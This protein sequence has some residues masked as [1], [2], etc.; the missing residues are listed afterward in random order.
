[1]TTHNRTLSILLIGL[2]I[3]Q[4]IGCTRSSPTN[5]V[6]IAELVG[7]WQGAYDATSSLLTT[8]DRPVLVLSSQH[9]FELD[10]IPFDWETDVFLFG[11]S[12]TW[13]LVRDASSIYLQLK[14]DLTVPH[15]SNKVPLP[16]GLNGIT[17]GIERHRTSI[18]LR[19]QWQDPD[20][21]YDIIFAMTRKETTSQ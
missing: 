14:F 21:H 2:V 9:R 20:L 10:L 1:M 13:E 19:Y 8:I 3:A 5:D 18:R 12:G 6:A 17:L 7:E 11:G 15:P 4:S 16:T